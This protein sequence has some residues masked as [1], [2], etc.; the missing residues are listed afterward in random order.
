[1]FVRCVCDVFAMCVAVFLRFFCAALCDVCAMFV[2][3]LCGVC[4][5]FVWCLCD[6]YAVPVRCL[7]GVCVVCML[8]SRDAYKHIKSLVC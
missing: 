6:V 3:C 5:V 2:R 1:M 7:C 8:L 4:A